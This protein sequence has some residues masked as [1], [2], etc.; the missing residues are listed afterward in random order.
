MSL[1]TTTLNFKTKAEQKHSLWTDMFAVF[2]DCPSTTFLLKE[3]I[4]SSLDN[5]VYKHLTFAKFCF[6]AITK[7][8]K[9]CEILF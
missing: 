8:F 7:H 6:Q 1:V 5:Y 4:K 3:F 9:T 2:A